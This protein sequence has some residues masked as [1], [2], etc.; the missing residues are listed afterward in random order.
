MTTMH[1]QSA[2]MADINGLAQFL[3]CRG[4]GQRG[5]AVD[6]M[7]AILTQ[8]KRE[9]GSAAKLGCNGGPHWIGLVGA[10]RLADRGDMINVDAEI[11]DGLLLGAII[12]GLNSSVP[13]GQGR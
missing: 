6:D 9:A 4:R 11:S 3:Q 13:E 5:I 12:P 8:V 7:A 1:F 10:A 2:A